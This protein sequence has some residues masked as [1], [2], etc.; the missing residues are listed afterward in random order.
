[1][2]LQPVT[3]VHPYD[4]P[5]LS[6]TKV[7]TP[8][9]KQAKSAP[10]G[11]LLQYDLL[12]ELPVLVIQT[13][14]IPKSAFEE[15]DA[16]THRGISR[17]SCTLYMDRK[18]MFSVSE[19][20]FDISATQ[21]QLAKE[22]EIS[23]AFVQADI[24][25]LDESQEKTGVTYHS[26]LFSK[27]AAPEESKDLNVFRPKDVK[28]HHDN[29]LASLSRKGKT[30]LGLKDADKG[31]TEKGLPKTDFGQQRGSSSNPP[32]Q[33]AG[34]EQPAADTGQKQVLREEE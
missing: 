27:V 29:T 3:M 4:K 11:C 17:N 8:T 10:K 31:N 26:L 1:M 16:H 13:R 21:T 25:F 23:D 15:Y 2:C 19:R 33:R 9:L 5:T 24:D 32:K 22:R 18:A 12:K 6:R 14:F 30:R 20:G 7:E 34:W 28:T